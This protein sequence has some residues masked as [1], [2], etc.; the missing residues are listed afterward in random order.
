M[1]TNDRFRHPGL[2]IAGSFLGAIAL[3][4]VLLSLPLATEAG[5]RA[6]VMEA[7]FTS[8]SAVT[9]TGLVLSDTGATFT[10]FGQA[11]IAVLIQLGGLGLM[12]FAV[13]VLSALGIPVGMPQRMILR[14]DL[15]QTSL[16]NLNVL[17]RVMYAGFCGSD[18]GIWY[19][20]CTEHASW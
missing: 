3:G 20:Q 1:A 17:V 6:T 16:S 5:E 18:R 13:L 2:V 4:T 11:V 7:L 9:V 12:T 14:E 15:N 8:T 10:G 19:R